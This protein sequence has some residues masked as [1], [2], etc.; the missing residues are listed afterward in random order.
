[1]KKP[2]GASSLLLAGL[3]VGVLGGEVIKEIRRDLQTTIFVRQQSSA[4]FQQFNGSLGDQDAAQIVL[5]DGSDSDKRP[6][7]SVGGRHDQET[8][9]SFNDAVNKVCSDQHNDCADLSNKGG[10]DFKVGDC[11]KQQEQCQSANTPTD[12]NDQFLYFC[13]DN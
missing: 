5:N 9:S 4:N 12:Q 1:M 13:D 2:W 7:K 3:A 8:Y 6:F 10:A 11:D